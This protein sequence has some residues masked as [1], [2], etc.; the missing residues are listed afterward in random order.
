MSR[1]R[2]GRKPEELWKLT[3]HRWGKDLAPLAGSASG[4]HS[5]IRLDTALGDGPKRP[6]FRAETNSTGRT[7]S[8]WDTE[9]SHKGSLFFPSACQ[10]LVPLSW[11]GPPLCLI[12]REKTEG[13]AKERRARMGQPKL[14]QTAVYPVKRKDSP[15]Q[16]GHK[17]YRA[18]EEGR[19]PMGPVS[20][21]CS[22]ECSG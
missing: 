10:P 9:V 8:G 18:S 16:K 21:R 1:A 17:G 22:A 11:P 4:E 2:P 20:D 6:R 12:K 19:H 5:S 15:R 3:H 7:S 13:I 14:L